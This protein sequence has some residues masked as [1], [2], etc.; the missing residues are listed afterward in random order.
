MALS[1]CGRRPAATMGR[2]AF[3]KRAATACAA[4]A[5]PTVSWAAEPDRPN[6]VV[7]LADDMGVG[8]VQ[9]LYPLGKIPTPYLD[10]LTR[11]GTAFTDAHSASAVCT[12]TRYGLLTGRY[13]WRTCLQEWVIAPYEPPL[14]AP[15]RLTLPGMLQKAGYHTACIG[16]WHLGWEWTGEGQGREMKADF[17]APIAHGPT[18]R[19]FDYYFGTHVPNFPPFTYIENDRIVDQPTAKNVANRDIVIGFDGAPM[20]PG[21]KF[22]NIMPDITD[23]A[24]AYIHDRAQRGT[25]FF[26]FFSQTAPHEPVSPS[27]RFAGKSGIAP[28]ADF[29]METDWSAGQVLDA[30]DEAGIADNTL[31]IFATDNGHSHYTGWD[32]LIAHGHHP[33]GPFRGHKSEIWE[34][35]H[36]V[37]FIVRWPGRVPEGRT[38]SQL[39]CLNDLMATCAALVGFALPEHAAED[40]FNL[41][42][43]LL[44]EATEPVRP[45]LVSHD[46]RGRFAIRQGPWKLVI[47]AE[48]ESEPD[49]QLYRLDIDIAETTDLS[50]E[51]PEKVDA[52]RRLLETYVA[53][54]RS[55]PGAPQLNDTDEIDIYHLPPERW[56]TPRTG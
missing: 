51:H 41:L 43:V 45:A 38:E 37:P 20:A 34:G 11:E 39:V 31:V 6:I 1:N 35:G 33:S 16:K 10:R 22:E 55:T 26:L 49:F 13:A 4:S 44:G 40:S 25:P 52:L 15:D 47:Y 8:D 53:D 7:I 32:E 30:I 14:I 2:R 19:G 36:R 5:W 48:K 24:V 29:V 12:P 46:V 54:G 17:T 50:A 3:L 27:S 18:T 42:P 28:I 9:A 56:A 21:W 23:R